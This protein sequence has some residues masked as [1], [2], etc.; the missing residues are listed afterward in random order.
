LDLAADVLDELKRRRRSQ[1]KTLGELASELLAG[2]LAAPPVASSEPLR[3]NADDLGARVDLAD[4]DA[5]RRAL[6][7]I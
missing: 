6:E 1:R 2:A 4:K 3:W 7:E 5:V